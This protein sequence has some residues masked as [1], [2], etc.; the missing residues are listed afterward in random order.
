MFKENYLKESPKV[1]AH[2]NI[3]ETVSYF[4][5]VFETESKPS[6]V[7]L[8]GEHGGGKS[9]MLFQLSKK[10]SNEVDWFF[11]DAWKYPRRSELWEGFITE[12][13]GCFG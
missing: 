3:A 10:N 13:E 1:D 4:N 5:D 8:L 11:F 6:L 9:T 12:G 7:A 2:I